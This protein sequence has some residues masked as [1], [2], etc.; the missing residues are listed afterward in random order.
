[1]VRTGDA[2]VIDLERAV[3]Q[4]VGEHLEQFVFSEDVRL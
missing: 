1:M 3:A 4:R 2:V